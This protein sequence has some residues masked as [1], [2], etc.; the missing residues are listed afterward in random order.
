MAKGDDA[1]SRNRVEEQ[2]GLSQNNLNNLRT[3]TLIPQNQTFWNNYTSSVDRANQDY[4]NLQ[5]GF[6]NFQDTGGFSDMDLANIR[7]RAL[8]PTRAVYSNAM[9]NVNRQRALQGGYSPGFGTL[10]GRM[11]REQSQGLSDAATNAEGMI[12]Q[13]VNQGKQFGLQGGANLYGMTPGAANMFGNQVLRSTDQ[14]L[15][16]EGLQGDIA[17]T[18][19]QGQLGASQLPGKWESNMGRINDIFSLGER[20]LFPWSGITGGMRGGSPNAGYPE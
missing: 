11:A 5:A 3:D 4:G 14:R 9:R 17:R 16:G 18:A 13:L 2:T 12:A 6:Q 19:I 15:A 10:Q 7:S 1:R 8:S 20:I